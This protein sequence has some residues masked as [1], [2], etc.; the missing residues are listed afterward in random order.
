MVLHLNC[1]E[2]FFNSASGVT[3]YTMLLTGYTNEIIT[4]FQNAIRCNRLT[5]TCNW[6]DLR[7]KLNFHKTLQL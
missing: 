5:S 1:F 6:L 4:I 7:K 3:S 2:V